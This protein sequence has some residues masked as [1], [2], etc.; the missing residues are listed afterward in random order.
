MAE[1]SLTLRTVARNVRAARARAGLSLEQLG[2]RA[3]VSKGALVAL[4]NAQG[5]PNLGTLVRLADALGL[6]VS[7][8]VDEPRQ[9]RVQIVDGAAAAPL[10][11]GEHGGWARLV[12]TTPGP[13]QVELW[14]WRLHPGEAYESH[15]HPAG[16]TETLTVT[17]GRMVLEV[18]GAGHP[19][20]AG[21]SA[22]FGADVGH[23]YRGA[24]DGPCDLI[25]TVHLPPAAP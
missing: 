24:G 15:P 16:V 13:A 19:L 10:W 23:A 8:L 6:A 18:G 12:L 9:G 14:H 21:A 7:D 5:N 2:V 20:A 11:R 1:V 4:E 22:T 3:Q 17:A 25:M